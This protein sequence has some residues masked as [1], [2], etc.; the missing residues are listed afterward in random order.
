MIISQLFHVDLQDERKKI[1]SNQSINK[2]I[3]LCGS[4]SFEIM[5]L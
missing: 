5:E 4:E 2:E 3:G 1:G